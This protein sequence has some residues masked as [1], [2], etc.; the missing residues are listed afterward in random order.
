M[1]KKALKILMN[2]YWSSTTGWKDGIFSKEDF[3]YALNQ[4]AVFLPLEISHDEAVIKLKEIVS[5]ITKEE[6]A[7]AFLASLGTR[8]LELR[9]ALGSYVF[10]A[11][12]PVHQYEI[13]DHFCK[14]CGHYK[15][16]QV[17]YDLNVLN[18]ERYK[19]GGIRHTTD[20]IYALLDLEQF[21]KVEKPMPSNEDYQIFANIITAIEGLDSNAKARD[22][23]KAI[24]KLLKSNKAERDTLI[25]ILGF[26]SIL[27][28]SE[29]KGFYNQYTNRTH[30]EP[31]PVHFC[32][33]DYPV[34]WWKREYG[35]NYEAL[36]HY[37]DF[38]RNHK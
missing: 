24:S 16:S 10:A 34:S 8:R 26:C 12:L 33:W 37:F 2:A 13:D 14:I 1:D 32:D 17:E 28:T 31:P 9:S 18:F 27:E 20:L 7:N 4:G 5:K 6:V 3:D 38:M 29:H 22:I 21:I 15:S 25:N 23:E 11:S 30:R 19:W 35:I 36:H